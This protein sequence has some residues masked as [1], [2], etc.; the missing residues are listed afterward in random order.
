MEG[1]ASNP[2]KALPILKI[3]LA[4]YGL[5]GRMGEAHKLEDINRLSTYVDMLTEELKREI[6]NLKTSNSANL[7]DALYNAVKTM[8]V[9]LFRLPDEYEV[10][11]SLFNILHEHIYYVYHTFKNNP[12]PDPNLETLLTGYPEYVYYM[13]EDE[14]LKSSMVGQAQQNAVRSM[15]NNPFWVIKWL[16][17]HFDQNIYHEMMRSIFNLHDHDA[18]SAHCYHWLKTK[19]ADTAAKLEELSD[20]KLLNALSTQPYIALIT[21]MEYPGVDLEALVSEIQS[22]PMWSY[23]WLKFVRNGA[24]PKMIQT[25]VKWVPWGVQYIHDLKPADAEELLDQMLKNP[26]NKYWKPWLDRYLESRK[27]SG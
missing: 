11:I 19:S 5:S 21:A 27:V 20:A 18:C 24:T 23:N 17:K 2:P 14:T 9:A 1:S 16:E 26:E 25:L 4:F 22:S 15:F 10:P 8:P 13:L 12:V 3:P 6:V 7:P